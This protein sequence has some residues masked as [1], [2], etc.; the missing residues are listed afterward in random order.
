MGLSHRKAP[1]LPVKG[2]GQITGMLL[3][4]L[5]AWDIT[6]PKLAAFFRFKLCFMNSIKQRRLQE[7][8]ATC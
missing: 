7:K 2:G 4:G 3:A 5:V 8:K 6:P 1:R